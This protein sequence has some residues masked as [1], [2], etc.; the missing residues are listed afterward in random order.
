MLMS[1][2]VNNDIARVLQIKSLVMYE[3]IYKKRRVNVF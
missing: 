3:A 2:D 1:K